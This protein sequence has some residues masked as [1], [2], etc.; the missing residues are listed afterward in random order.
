MRGS[1]GIGQG[2]RNEEK[3]GSRKEIRDFR[4]AASDCGRAK[5]E[6]IRRLMQKRRGQ[7]SGSGPHVCGGA[8]V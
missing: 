6:A 3:S 4:I 2:N 8:S 7:A 1:F 5:H